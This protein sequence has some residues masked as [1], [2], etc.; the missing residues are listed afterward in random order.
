AL[1]EIDARHEG[2]EEPVRAVLEWA[3]AAPGGR[4]KLGV[5]GPLAEFIDV[6]AEHIEWAGPFLAPFLE[7]LVVRRSA[8]VPAIEAAIADRGLGRVRMIPLDAVA[9]NNGN[10]NSRSEPAGRGKGAWDKGAWD[11]GDAR[12]A[13]LVRLPKEL[14][15]L[16]DVLFG[17][18]RLLP[19]GTAPYPMPEPGPGC[20]QWLERSGRFHLDYRGV[21]AMGQSAEPALGILR[22]RGEIEAAEKSL[23]ELAQAAAGLREE[24]HRTEAETA[25]LTEQRQALQHARQADALQ[26]HALD[27]RCV[28]AEQEGERL[29][30]SR[31]T[32]EAEH[33]QIAR[34]LEAAQQQ[35]AELLRAE[36][37]LRERLSGSERELATARERS[38]E[39]RAE[40]ARLGERLTERKVALERILSRLEHLR[41]RAALLD[42]EEDALAAKRAECEEEVARQHE[43]L[44]AH[45]TAVEEATAGLARLHKEQE[46]IR[47]DLNQHVQRHEEGEQQRVALAGRLKA[48][49]TARE[50]AQAKLHEMETALAVERTRMEQAVEQLGEAPPEAAGRAEMDEA[51]L[52]ARWK[53]RQERLERM[54]GVNL[55]APEEHGALQER[56]DFL[57]LQKSDLEL[58]CEDLKESIRRMNQESRKR[59]KETFD[60]VNE[61]FQRVFPE[62]FGG[63]EGRL[64]LTDSEDLLLAGV[65][66]EA[67]PPG[68]KL[69][70]LSLLSG[71]EKALC[72]IALIFSFFLIKPSPF[73]LLDEVDAPLDDANVGRFNRMVQSM[74]DRTQFIIITHNRRTMES[75]NLLFGITM[76]E[77]GVSKVVS[78][79][80]SDPSG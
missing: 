24:L 16:R 42:G 69:Q 34:D 22:R 55:A 62:V 52:E 25:E 57:Q 43:Q 26:Q 49:Q 66:I 4:A 12:F 20:T 72:A 17:D 2:L 76:E 6:D 33:G 60:Q 58:A 78:V 11:K 45:R 56:M 71:G 19:Q 65:D 47:R 10:G 1:A 8:D 41:E 36:T 68:K 77:A 75:G 5:L 3:D 44:D 73:C 15:P 14:E 7:L 50:Q 80:L 74:T 21:V 79:N 30:R 28:H 31:D 38:A 54:G 61:T 48:A 37:A 27:Q 35:R 59:F 32:L 67:Q 70:T 40:A 23:G 9:R 18:V 63:G 64:V 51:E 46:A 29:A 53:E 13:G 39:L